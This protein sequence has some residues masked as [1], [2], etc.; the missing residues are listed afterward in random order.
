MGSDLTSLLPALHCL[1]GCD[2]TS[3]IGTKKA[4]M[5]ANP[6][7][8]LVNF[9]TSYT[10]SVFKTAEQF[11]VKVLKNSSAANDFTELRQEIYQLHILICH[12]LA[13]DLYHIL[14]GHS[15]ILT[16]SHKL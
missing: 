1:T 3:K 2:T 9:G 15:T 6:V 8:F 11:L 12:L 5:K 16:S 7:K 10:R 13:R 4:A 14:R